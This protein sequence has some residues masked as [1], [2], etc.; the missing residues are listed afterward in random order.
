[1]DEAQFLEMSRSFKISRERLSQLPRLIDGLMVKELN[2]RRAA[3]IN[4]RNDLNAEIEEAK[5]ERERLQAE[6]L[7]RKALIPILRK[8]LVDASRQIWNTKTKNEADRIDELR[9]KFKE[10]KLTL[11]NNVTETIKSAA[12]LWGT[13]QMSPKLMEYVLYRVE[14]SLRYVSNLP[15]LG[16]EKQLLEANEQYK[17][18]YDTLCRLLQASTDD[19]SI[20][21]PPNIID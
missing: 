4:R 1:M 5:E 7:E 9:K 19:D 3:L 14:E 11:E 10:T 8:Q 6:M 2:L 12:T 18:D 17:K 13:E 16:I 20:K 15:N 21:L